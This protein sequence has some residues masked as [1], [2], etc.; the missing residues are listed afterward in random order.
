MQSMYRLQQLPYVGVGGE[1]A[2]EAISP[3]TVYV[4]LLIVILDSVVSAHSNMCT[5]FFPEVLRMFGE[6]DW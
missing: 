4:T 5:G 6:V 2:P 3:L 1:G